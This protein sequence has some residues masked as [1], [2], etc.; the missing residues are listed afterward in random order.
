MM[1]SLVWVILTDG[2]KVEVVFA[3][4]MA[5]YMNMTWLLKR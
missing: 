5:V 1:E 4:F 3:C 2:T